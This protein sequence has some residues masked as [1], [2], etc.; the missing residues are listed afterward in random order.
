MAFRRLNPHLTTDDLYYLQC[1]GRSC[2]F[3]CD[4]K[5]QKKFLGVEF[6]GKLVAEKN[7]LQDQ[8]NEVKSIN[9]SINQLKT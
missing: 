6:V 2:L 8:L 7:S 1:G 4:K 9:Q 5:E 3:D